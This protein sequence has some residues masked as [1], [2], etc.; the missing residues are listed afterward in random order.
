MAKKLATVTA[1]IKK[2]K[3]DSINY[4]IT[5]YSESQT[6]EKL[7]TGIHEAVGMFFSMMMRQKID[8]HTISV[9]F[10]IYEK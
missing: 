1:R 3:P 9:T 5:H 4:K 10:S 7:P 8:E 2:S 6:P